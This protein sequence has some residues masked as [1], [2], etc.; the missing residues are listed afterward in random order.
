LLCR[1]HTRGMVFGVED[2]PDD[3]PVPAFS[4]RMV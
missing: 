3:V 2:Y 4:P 1:R